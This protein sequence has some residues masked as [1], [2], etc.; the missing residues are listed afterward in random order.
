MTVQ[1]HTLA[2]ACI[3]PPATGSTA[4]SA[5]VR[6]LAWHSVNSD[7][8][9]LKVLSLFT[10]TAKNEGISSFQ[11]EHCGSLAG[12]LAKQGVN[13]LLCS[14]MQSRLLSNIHHPCP[15]MH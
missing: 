7:A 10:A 5:G 12:K 3:K 6:W 4:R 1:S 14:S 15:R 13:L 2:E 11:S 8:S 9:L